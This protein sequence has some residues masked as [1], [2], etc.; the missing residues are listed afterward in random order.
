MFPKLPFN[1][2]LLPKWHLGDTYRPERFP[3]N[4]SL[5]PKWHL[6]NK[7][8]PEMLLNDLTIENEQQNCFLEKAAVP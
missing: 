3:F 5:L 1:E 2:N 7:Y 4:E 8:W 6:S